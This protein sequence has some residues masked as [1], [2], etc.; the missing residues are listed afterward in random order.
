MEGSGA[1]GKASRTQIESNK[2]L[3][4]IPCP[5][6]HAGSKRQEQ[7]LQDIQKQRKQGVWQMLYRSER[8]HRHAGFHRIIFRI[9]IHAYSGKKILRSTA[10]TAICSSSEFFH[11]TGSCG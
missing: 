8:V 10:I 6:F 5:Q 3:N 9:N 1:L 2:G 11:P 4:E 7:G